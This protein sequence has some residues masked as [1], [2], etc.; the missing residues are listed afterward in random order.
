MNKLVL[1]AAVTSVVALAGCGSSS[2]ST[3]AS[4]PAGTTSAPAPA[5]TSS[6]PSAA[7][8][9]PTATTGKSVDITFIQGVAGDPFYQTMAC[10]AKAEA[11][12][13]GVKL[14]VQGAAQ[15]DVS[16][17]TPLVNSVVSAKPDAL[18]IAPNDSKAMI[19]PLK[20]AAAAGVK[21]GLVD[22]TLSDT[23][24]TSFGISTDNVAAGAAAADA[25]ANLIGKKGSVLLAGEQPG[26]TTSEQRAQGF[27]TELKKYPGITYI[28]N[29][30]TNTGGVS[31][32][33]ALVSAKISATPDLAGVFALST[34]QSEGTDNAIRSSGKAGKIKVVGFDAGPTQVDQLK[35]GV[36]QA[37]VAQEPAQIGTDAVDNAA[38][39][40]RGQTVQAKTGTAAAIITADNYKEPAMAKFLYST[41]CA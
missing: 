12:R 27:T 39:L 22:T 31:G 25:L 32:I 35:Q 34:D 41:T 26:V 4:P 15:W 14:N 21:V 29:V 28:G 23:S 19:P 9:S 33:S 10:G 1:T 40:G 3:A 17:Q 36:V 5:P 30:F 11:K 2:S 24:F 37:L 20:A 16:L 6:A 38:A 13:I 7:S 8:S 18:F